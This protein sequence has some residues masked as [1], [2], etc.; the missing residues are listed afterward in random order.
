MEQV[1]A[2]SE[3]VMLKT[4]ERPDADD[5]PAVYVL[6]D[7]RLHP[8][9]EGSF[10]GFPLTAR[11]LAASSLFSATTASTSAAAAKTANSDALIS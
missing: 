4:H 7:G 2:S 3:P 11:G 1:I 5:F 9:V 8:L 6:R 10:L